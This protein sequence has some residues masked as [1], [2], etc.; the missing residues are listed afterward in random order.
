MPKITP[1]R[2]VDYHASAEHIFPLLVC[3]VI[4]ADTVHGYVFRTDGNMQFLTA[5]PHSSSP[6]RYQYGYWDWP[7]RGDT[8]TLVSNSPINTELTAIAHHFE[9]AADSHATNDQL[10]SDT[11]SVIVSESK[12]D[13]GPTTN[14][15]GENRQLILTIAYP[16]LQAVIAALIARLTGASVTP[17]QPS[18]D[19]MPLIRAAADTAPLAV[20]HVP[21][22][23]PLE[24]FSTWISSW[25]HVIAGKIGEFVA[26]ERGQ[27]LDAKDQITK[28]LSEMLDQLPTI[29]ARHEFSNGSVAH[30]AS[31]LIM[32]DITSMTELNGDI[33]FALR[34]QIEVH[35]M[36][37][38]DKVNP[39]LAAI[40]VAAAG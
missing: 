2:I 23:T 31:G 24:I 21:A 30:E 5:V 6:M 12:I 11:M 27:F 13:D 16:L 37:A 40:P 33:A 9:A 20:P 18:G 7:A 25:G 3:A 15:A 36:A 38:L 17:N 1:N 34:E 19:T 35:L 10:L 4:G 39:R 8:G 32:R 22:H 14:S 26:M 28:H 29:P